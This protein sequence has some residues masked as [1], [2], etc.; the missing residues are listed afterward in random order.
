[1]YKCLPIERGGSRMEVADTIARFTHLLRAGEVGP[2]L[3]RGR[4]QPQR[5]GRGRE[6]RLRRGPDREEPSRLPR[7]VRVPARRRAARVQRLP[8]R[9]D[10]LRARIAWLEPKSDRRGLRGS[11][12]VARQILPARRA[13]A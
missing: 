1:V 10:T 6:R 2:D 5:P 11:L 12:D 13:R 7:A 3:S 9:G 4:A 8:A